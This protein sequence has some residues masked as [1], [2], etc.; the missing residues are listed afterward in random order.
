MLDEGFFPRTVAGVHAADLGNRD[1]AL[2]D[3]AEE[4]G[5]KEVV[6]AVGPLARWPTGQVAAVIL[7]AGAVT[8]LGHHL[9]IVVGAGK[10]A[11]RFKQGPSAHQLRVADIQLGA[12]ALN[13]AIEGRLV[14][15]EV[16]G[17][18]DLQPLVAAEDFACQG[19]DGGDLFDLV[20]EERNADRGVFIGWPQL[21]HIT[22][23]PIFAAAEVEI[24]ALVL[25]VHQLAEE[26]V[27]LDRHAALDLDGQ[28]LV[29]TR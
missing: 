19:R 21:D 6:Q 18:I 7:D 2:V 4:V 15:H 27:A 8:D 13:R 10:D 22:A 29:R 25:D 5:G 1:V 20:A 16:L 17:G 11:L 28:I 12:N 24:A 14:N 26:G 9:D 3:D 23:H